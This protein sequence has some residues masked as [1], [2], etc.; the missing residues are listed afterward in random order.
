[1][2]DGKKAWMEELDETFVMPDGKGGLRAATRA[3]AEASLRG[4]TKDPN[5][6]DAVGSKKASLSVVPLPVIAE[7][8]LGMMEG[9]LKYGRHN[10]RFNTGTRASVMFDATVRHLFAWF[11]GEDLDPDSE[12]SHVTKAI[13]S[14]VVL[15]DAMMRGK[16]IDDRAPRTEN[17]YGELNKRAEALVAKY[18]NVNPQH[19]TIKDTE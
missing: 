17:L 15:R 11:E 2:S 9:A 14:L 3:E 13:C 1:M 10:Y 5:P 8:G 12:L 16:M 6:K 7:V 18:G 19:Y 4:G